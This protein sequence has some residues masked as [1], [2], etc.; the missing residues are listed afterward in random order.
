MDEA[1]L[2][3]V[4]E[5]TVR[6]LNESVLEIVSVGF[7]T[8]EVF[9]HGL[10]ELTARCA[11]N[12]KLHA[13][14]WTTTDLEGYEPGNTAQAMKWVGRHPQIRRAAV[15]TRSQ[16]LAS[17]THIGRVLIP[18]LET[19]SFRLRAEALEW[20]TTPLTGRPRTRSSNRHKAA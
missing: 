9:E 5:T 11:E 20:F 4:G 10:A 6:V 18:G 8:R 14:M 1:E 3:P 12:P 19:R 17:L 15:V 13:L 16:V 2:R 7:I